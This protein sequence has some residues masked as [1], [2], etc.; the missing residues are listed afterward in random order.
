MLVHANGSAGFLAF[1]EGQTH[2]Y[3]RHNRGPDRC[4]RPIRAD[5]GRAPSCSRIRLIVIGRLHFSASIREQPRA[6]TLFASTEVFSSRFN[7]TLV[8]LAPSERWV[9]G[10]VFACGDT[11]Q[12]VFCTVGLFEKRSLTTRYGFR[13][14]D[15]SLF[16]FLAQW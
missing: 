4:A 6:L 1:R 12:H 2:P 15:F 16:G 5:P 10:L 9:L 13:V 11:S 3:R 8:C 7:S 14:S